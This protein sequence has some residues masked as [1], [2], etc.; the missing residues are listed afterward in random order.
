MSIPVLATYDLSPNRD[1]GQC[2]FPFPFLDRFNGR[3]CDWLVLHGQC[4]SASHDIGWAL[5]VVLRAQR[6]MMGRTEVLREREEPEPEPSP[7][8][9]R[10]ECCFD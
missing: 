1:T 5:V 2:T 7:R 10:S 9:E 6:E 3:L 8:K 4:A